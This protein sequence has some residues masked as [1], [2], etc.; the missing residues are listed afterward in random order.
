[1]KNRGFLILAIAC[2]ALGL[3]SADA[4]AKGREGGSCLLFP[5]Y[6]TGTGT[7][8]TANTELAVLSITN[9]GP[10]TIQVHTVFVGTSDCTPK[11]RSFELTPNDTFSFVDYAWI[12]N[13]N[14]VGFFYAYA[15]EWN[16]N[17]KKWQEMDYDYLVGQELIFESWNPANPPALYSINAVTFECIQ[18][19][20]AGNDLDYLKLDGTEYEIAPNKLIFPRFFGQDNPLTG[21][22]FFKSSAILINLSGGQ[23]FTQE[24]VIAV[25]NDSEEPFSDTVKFRC[26]D[27]IDLLDISS[28]TLESN[29]ASSSI[30]DEIYDLDPG[31]PKK[32]GWMCI[33]S[34]Y[35]WIPQTSQYIQNVNLYGVLLEVVANKYSSADLPFEQFNP[36]NNT[37]SLWWTAPWAP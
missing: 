7:P 36:A 11:N 23:H 2:L 17:T 13:K 1:M 21:P 15:R 33:E 27:R 22:V 20:V 28:F 4:T 3:L 30:A 18:P 8:G 24:A 34:D 14:D 6:S 25:Y 19:N 12:I 26:W 31:D 29:L 5:F 10:E 32:T 16:P 37:G 9:T 35:S